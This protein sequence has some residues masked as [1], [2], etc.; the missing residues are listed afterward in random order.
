MLAKIVHKMALRGLVTFLVLVSCLSFCFDI[1]CLGQDIASK[2]INGRPSLDANIQQVVADGYGVSDEEATKNAIQAAVQQVVGAV[3]ETQTIVENDELIQDKI[4]TYASGFVTKVEQ[5]PVNKKNEKGIFHVRIKA[6]VERKKLIEKLKAANVAVLTIDGE[7]LFA[8]VL[9]KGQEEKDSR[10]LLI[11]AFADYPMNVFKAT[12]DAKPKILEQSDDRATLEFT[13]R[14]GVD[15]NAYK[16]FQQRINEI[17]PKIAIA[18]GD[19]SAK[20]RPTTSRPGIRSVK[21]FKTNPVVTSLLPL[22]NWRRQL[23]APIGGSGKAGSLVIAVATSQTKARDSVAF[24]YYQFNPVLANDIFA[25]ASQE[26]RLRLSLFNAAGELIIAN[27]Y[28]DPPNMIEPDLSLRRGWSRTGL[29]LSA[30]YGVH[31]TEGRQSDDLYKNYFFGLIV[32]PGTMQFPSSSEMGD[33]ERFQSYPSYGDEIDFWNESIRTEQIKLSLDE[34][35]SITEVKVELSF[36]SVPLPKP[37]G[38]R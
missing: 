9:S 8:E 13:V 37:Q 7:S 32:A 4:I 31:S 21:P 26:M 24:K 16:V 36:D 29:P 27:E 15:Q 35:R 19:F 30:G 10:T 28:K 1:Y 25:I 2:A 23:S 3:V 6:T 33:M 38:F 12:V 17:L 22:E 11:E 20:F 5:M 34:I 14:F 18:K